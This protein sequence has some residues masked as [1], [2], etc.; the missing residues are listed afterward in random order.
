[1]DQLRPSIVPD[2]FT[3]QPV[4]NNVP[5]VSLQPIVSTN[6]TKEFSVDEMKEEPTKIK[7]D[8]FAGDKPND[9]IKEQTENAKPITSTDSQYINPTINTGGNPLNP[10]K[11]KEDVRSSVNTMIALLDYILSFVGQLIASEGVQSQYTADVQ[12][13]KILADALT[14]FL[15]EKQIK[16]SAGVALLLAFLGAYGFML[17]KAGKKR[18][19][20]IKQKKTGKKITP[21][22]LSKTVKPIITP[23]EMNLFDLNH[24]K[25]N[26]ITD[27]NKITEPLIKPS[28]Q[29]PILENIY[30]EN[31][32]DGTLTVNRIAKWLNPSSEIIAQSKPDLYKY[33]QNG[34][35][36][37]YIRSS[38]TK[39]T[40]T[41]K[42]DPKSGQPV[43]AGKPPRLQ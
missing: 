6:N 29:K 2:N 26:P 18:Y 8:F 10:P 27:F 16:M 30:T 17:V 11:T 14:D 28:I 3:V 42:Y 21:V 39:K 20:L 4:I 1:M 34:I 12:Q 19:D 33:I 23:E 13:K 25:N 40:R 24:I 9:F 37:M 5:I 32:I 31:K 38:R 43:L 7:I 41:V 36:P 15:Y 35:Y 22:E